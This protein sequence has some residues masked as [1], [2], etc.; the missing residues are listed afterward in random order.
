VKH[1]RLVRTAA[2]AHSRPE[3]RKGG[4]GTRQGVKKSPSCVQS[5]DRTRIHGE[6]LQRSGV[7]RCGGAG[8]MSWG[9]PVPSTPCWE[10]SPTGPV[11]RRV[12][13]FKAACCMVMKGRPASLPPPLPCPACSQKHSR[14]PGS[15][16][17][18]LLGEPSSVGC[19]GSNPNGAAYCMCQAGPSASGPQLSQLYNGVTMSKH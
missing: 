4:G 7:T 16:S 1:P 8:D 11:L 10:L 12:S 19:P 14:G 17:P 5:P 6:E 3:G 18:T 13:G 2:K 15:L 9:G